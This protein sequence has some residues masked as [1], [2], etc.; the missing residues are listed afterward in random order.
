MCPRARVA[1]SALI[2]CARQC[3][4]VVHGEAQNCQNGARAEDLLFSLAF[5]I[6]KTQSKTTGYFTILKNISA[7]I[8][9]AW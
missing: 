7:G 5:A 6:V 9:F 8:Q 4:R 3:D 1:R 2:H